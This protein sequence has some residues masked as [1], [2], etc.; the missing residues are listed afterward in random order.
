MQVEDRPDAAPP[1]PKGGG[2]GD[3]EGDRVFVR[4]VEGKYS[5]REA[6]ER[7]KRVP[8]VIKGNAQ[9]WKG[10]PQV[11]S[12]HLLRPENEPFITQTL[13]VHMQEFAPGTEAHKHGHQNEAMFYILEGH[14]HDIHDGQRYEWQAGDVVAVHNDS[15]HQHFNDD[16]DRP[17][18]VLIMKSKPLYMFLGL[19]FQEKIK[20][21]PKNDTG[22]RPAGPIE[23]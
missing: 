21:S 1:K 4:G 14:G 20:P 11:W 7:R 18:R 8:R 12:K 3:G 13:H 2:G 19:M 5:V 9:P 6:L 22:H 16:P 10:G 15:V 17:A 23:K